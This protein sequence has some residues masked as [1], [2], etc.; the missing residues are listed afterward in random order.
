MSTPRNFADSL[1]LCSERRPQVLKEQCTC[2]RKALGPADEDVYGHQSV[3]IRPEPLSKGKKSKARNFSHRLSIVTALQGGRAWWVLQEEGLG[4][5][6]LRV[7]RG[8]ES[9]ISE[10]E[11]WKVLQWT[12]GLISYRQSMGCTGPAAS[13]TKCC[14]MEILRRISFS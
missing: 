3:I 10:T 11:G 9:C 1:S 2:F 6:N 12:S 14:G 13:K 5:C 4:C 7:G 8:K